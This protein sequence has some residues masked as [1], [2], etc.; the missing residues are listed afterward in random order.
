MFRSDDITLLACI[1]IVGAPVMAVSTKIMLRA[2]TDAVLRVRGAAPSAEVQREL[3]D[4]RAQVERMSATETF[5][6]QLQ[7]PAPKPPTAN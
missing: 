2:A 7:A 5:Y 1:A 3:E 4:L 6:A